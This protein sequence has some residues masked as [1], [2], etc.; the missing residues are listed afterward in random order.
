MLIPYFHIYKKGY[1]EYLYSLTLIWLTH[2]LG[3]TLGIAPSNVMHLYK[4]VEYHI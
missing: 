1:D 4:L 2:A 3:L